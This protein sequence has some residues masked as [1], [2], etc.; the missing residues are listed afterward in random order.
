MAEILRSM[1]PLMCAL[2]IS[3]EWIVINPPPEFFQ[4]TKKI[5]NLLQGAE[6]S[7]SV[8]ELE[9]YHGSIKDVA[10]QFRRHGL[11][12]DIWFLHDPQLLPLAQLLRENL[13]A[14]WLWVAHI[15]LTTPNQSVLDSLL[16]LTSGYD[17]LVF[18][19]E[20]YVPR[21]L[22]GSPRVCI[23]PPAIDPVS[24][25]NTPLEASEA[26]RIIA[27]MGIDP[28][29][30][31]ITQV[32]RFDSWKDPWGV[33]DAYRV[34]RR[35]IPNLQLALLGL[36]QAADDPEALEVLNS[37]TEYAA[38]DPDI[39]MYYSCDG[40]P[41]S[42]D[43]I[44]NAFQVASQVVL[45]KSTREG[46]GLTV[47]EAMWKGKPVIG[48]NVG[49]IRLQIENG[50]SGYL[51]DTPEEC[52][53]RIVQLVGHPDLMQRI[54]QAARESVRQRFL[55]PRLALDYLRVAESTLAGNVASNGHDVQAIRNLRFS[56]ALPF[57]PPG[58]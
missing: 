26:S 51:V 36:S 15:D 30:P 24:V 11:D 20:S 39:H 46:F 1:T 55:L 19:M 10:S 5:H 18:S 34:A 12:A 49:G 4:V 31:L 43:Q 9:I 27:A 13:G 17:S 57:P 52:A 53:W 35:D 42:I 28:A 50:V 54:G 47:A 37:V 38:Q 7:L 58:C 41:G 48:G 29:R 32:S 45:Q 40:L 3:T 8:S 14:A 56:P 16:P 6:G 33:I 21:E 44:V 25:K 22:A 23:T 2:G